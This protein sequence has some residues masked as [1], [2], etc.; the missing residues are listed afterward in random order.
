MKAR[1]FEHVT[2]DNVGKRLAILMDGIVYSAPHINER[3][4]AAELRITGSFTT[5]E[6]SELAILLNSKPGS[7]QYPHQHLHHQTPWGQTAS[8]AEPW[9]PSSASL[10]VA[11]FMLIYYK[12][13]GLITDFILVF[14]VGFILAMLTLFGTRSPCPASLASSSPLE[15]LWIIMY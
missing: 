12:L 5:S 11:L 13:A 15:W 8:K 2:S 10:A 7:P 6:A 4:P 1:R 3:I 9:L 14:N